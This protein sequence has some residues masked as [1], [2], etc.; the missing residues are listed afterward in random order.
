MMYILNSRQGGIWGLLFLIVVIS[1]GCGE[2]SGHKQNLTTASTD[3]WQAPDTAALASM[4]DG[5]L[6]KYGRELI[7]NT[8]AYLGPKGKVAQISNGMNC[9]NCHLDAGTRPNGNNFASVAFTYPRFRMRSGKKESIQFRVE[10]CMQRSLN[11]SAL[12]SNGKEMKAMVAYIKWLGKDVT[13]NTVIK[14]DPDLPFIERAASIKNGAAVYALRCTTCHGANGNGLAKP[15]S[16]GYIYP[17]LWGPYSYNTSA[18]NY[19][20]SRLAGFVKHN[21][22]YTVAPQAPVLTDEEAWDVA[23][24]INSQKRPVKVFP[25]DWPVLATKPVDYPFGPYADTFS[26]LQHKYGPFTAIKKASY[27]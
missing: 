11:G 16:T 14:K 9:G 21:M 24:F 26:E 10:D 12:D 4:P 20:L 2:Q 15:D 22:P 8:A 3:V 13:S 17:P 25:G 7:A 5:N 6:I 23:A 27:K 18:G 1:A 19:M